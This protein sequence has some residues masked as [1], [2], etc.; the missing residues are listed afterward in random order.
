MC[1]RT[2][3]G[4]FSES[5][6]KLLS[7]LDQLLSAKCLTDQGKQTPTTPKIYLKSP[8]ITYIILLSSR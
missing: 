3:L 7:E 5:K 1:A 8:Y 6:E 2:F 4:L